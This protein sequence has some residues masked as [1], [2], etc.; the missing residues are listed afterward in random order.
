MRLYLNSMIRVLNRYHTFHATAC[1]CVEFLLIHS[2][3]I[4]TA[5][6][7]F[8]VS[9][10]IGCPSPLYVLG[11]FCLLLSDFMYYDDLYNLSNSPEYWQFTHEALAVSRSGS[12]RRRSHSYVLL[13]ST[14]IH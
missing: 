3:V 4:L 11:T 8:S 5:S 6:A 1:F 12:G 13:D 2:A 14:V 9:N 10:L 7:W